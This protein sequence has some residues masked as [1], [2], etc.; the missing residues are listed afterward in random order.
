MTQIGRFSKLSTFVKKKLILAN[1]PASYLSGALEDAIRTCY[2]LLLLLFCLFQ[3]SILK[4]YLSLLFLFAFF[5]FPAPKGLWD[6]FPGQGLNSGHSS[7]SAWI[8]TTRSL[9]NSLPLY[10]LRNFI[11][12]YYIAFRKKNST[13]FVY[14]KPGDMYC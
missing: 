3:T 6:L 11:N 5:F 1:K 10:F 9:G 2:L 8:L 7:E 13:T 12:E 14:Q 4:P